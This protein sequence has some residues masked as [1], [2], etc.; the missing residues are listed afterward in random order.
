[1]KITYFDVDVSVQGDGAKVEDGRRG[2]HDVKRN[3]SVTKLSTKWPITEHVIDSGECHHQGG[4]ESVGDGQGGQ[5]EVS[6]FP[7]TSVGENGSTDERI[8]GD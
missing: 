8:S 3:P 6:D 2:A 4:H 1:V 5:K 7:E